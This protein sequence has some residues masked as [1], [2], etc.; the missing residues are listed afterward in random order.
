MIEKHKLPEKDIKEV[1]FEAISQDTQ[2]TNREKIEEILK[3][4]NIQ[5]MVIYGQE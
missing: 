4:E 2:R 1:E 3:Q 5:M